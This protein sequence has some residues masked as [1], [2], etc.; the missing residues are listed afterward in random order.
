MA[1]NAAI[2]V[3]VGSDAGAEELVTA[4]QR[5]ADA[6][7]RRWEAV[8]VETPAGIDQT[9][10]AA[11]ALDLAARLGATVATL[12]AGTV[13]DGLALHLESTGSADLVM[14]NAR[15]RRR[16][17]GR[18]SL[19][20]A[21]TRRRPDLTVHLVPVDPRRK[22]GERRTRKAV[23]LAAY[24][25]A[26]GGVA[27]TIIIGLLLN[28]FAGLRFLSV[29][30]LFPVI[31]AAA[32]SGVKPALAA[33]L[34]SAL[35]FNFF[36]LEPV[37]VLKPSLQSLVMSIVLV[38]VGLYTGALTASLRGR[39]I[40]SERSA[41][42]NARIAAFAIELTKVADW[43]A[44]SR[45]IT[46]QVSALLDVQSIIVREIG[47]KLRIAASFPPGIALETLDQ[48][49]L[50]LAWER[51]EPTGNGTKMTSA[52]NWQFQPL[53]TSLGTL[54]ILGLARENEGEVVP[55]H[56]KVLLSTL[57]AQAALSLERLRLEEMRIDRSR[58]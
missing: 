37:S 49:A 42:E 55:A 54:A 28:K 19:V 35:G 24:G 17:F 58:S 9:A 47:G 45:T 32:R 39:S 14:G 53:R 11:E 8:H 20:R 48:A 41:H 56:R 44:T 50:D 25:Y 5:L 26:A 3:A 6:L 57:M 7:G 18:Q 21:I 46:T 34:L 30:F 43:A 10:M 1:E 31:A 38:L 22:S 2:V 29:L 40:L 4:G 52:A 27:A 33:A 16:L 51:G 23:P 36:F 13:A 15:R 12:P